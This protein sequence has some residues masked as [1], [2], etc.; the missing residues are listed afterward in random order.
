MGDWLG[1]DTIAPYKRQF[2]NFEEARDVV[3]AHRFPTKTEYE[4][5]TRSDE[6]PSDIPALPSRTYAKAG[7]LSWG[8]WLGV[9]NRWNKTSLLAFV[10]SIVPLLN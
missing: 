3:R 1:T 9:Y 4:A 8:D 6:R 10:S 7:W 5:W 2:L